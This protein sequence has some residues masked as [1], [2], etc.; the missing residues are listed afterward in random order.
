MHQYVIN[1]FAENASK[2]TAVETAKEKKI[3]QSLKQK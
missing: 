2:Q 1:R 3:K